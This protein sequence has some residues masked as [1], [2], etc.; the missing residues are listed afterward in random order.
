M[1]SC[2]IWMSVRWFVNVL[3]LWGKQV[4]ACVFMET[5]LLFQLWFINFYHINIIIRIVHLLFCLQFMNSYYTSMIT[6]IVHFLYYHLNMIYAKN[7][8]IWR[9]LAI[10]MHK[11][12][13]WFIIRKVLVIK[14]VNWFV[15]Y[16]SL[17]WMI[18]CWYN[19]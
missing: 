11:T 15:M 18:F 12:D 9:S 8:S 10:N 5:Y 19:F 16:W 4:P 3:G 14:T 7:N 13:K 17:N 1:V 6:R 2:Y